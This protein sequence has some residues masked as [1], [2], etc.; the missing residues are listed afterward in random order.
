MPAMKPPIPLLAL[1]FA[2]CVGYTYTATTQTAATAK[3]A[4]CAFD[5]LTTRPERAY[6]ELGVVE[7]GGTP[8]TGGATTAGAFKD[9]VANAVCRAGGDAVITEVNGMGIYVRGTVLKYTGQSGPPPAAAAPPPVAPY[10][11]DAPAA[12]AAPPAVVAL[13]GA[14]V[15]AASAEV[16]S[17]PFAV[18][19]VVTVVSQGQRL[20]VA[21]TSSNGWR[22]ATLSDGRKGYVQDAQIKVDAS[23]P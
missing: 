5:L 22:S 19:P 11:G 10:P 8:N 23:A 12:P 18:A 14:V 21:P 16:R 17:A 2:G 7:H 20:S 15:S 3:P 1:L 6:A 4:G 13:P 9:M